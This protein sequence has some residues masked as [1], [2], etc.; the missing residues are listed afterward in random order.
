MSPG[1]EIK[2]HFISHEWLSTKHPDPSSVQLRLLQE[3]FRQILAGDGADLFNEDDWRTFS[4][5]VS[6]FWTSK[7]ADGEGAAQVDKI[8]L[9]SFAQHVEEG[10]VW[11]DF[12][13]IPHMIDVQG[14]DTAELLQHEMKQAFAVHEHRKD[15]CGFASWRGRGWCRLEEWG[16][17]LS[18]RCLMPFVVTD[19]PKISTNSVASFMPT[20]STNLRG[21]HAWASFLFC[22]MNGRC[23][24][25]A[26][27]SSQRQERKLFTCRKVDQ[28]ESRPSDASGSSDVSAASRVVCDLWRA[29]MPKI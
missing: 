8:T 6:A 13:S 10:V 28:C 16:N 27:G 26:S 19:A 12:S 9:L 23:G 4:Q 17:F 20:T 5:G 25:T 1:T 21:Y 29:Q 24:G 14:A 15:I 18:K 2:V 3:V 7:L 22:P 11:L